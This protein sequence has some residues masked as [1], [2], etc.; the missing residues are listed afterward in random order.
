MASYKRSIFLINPKFQYRFS[1]FFVSFVLLATAI[2]P[3][4]IFDLFE[5]IIEMQ[6]EMAA[7]FQ[8]TRNS[9]LLVLGLVELTI[10]CFLF[11][12]SIFLSHKIAGP[13][14]KLT[15]HFEKI[16]EG[17]EIKPV[18][19]RDGD[20]FKEI[21][22]EVNLT[23]EYFANQRQEDF[24]YLDEVSAYIANLS[25]VVPEDKKPVL[26]EIQSNL[27]KIQSRNLENQL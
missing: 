19:F 5:K 14:Y 10:L 6:P 3:F 25:L 11:I 13:M 1:F 8:S 16:R 21:A 22:H 18:F 23:L 15:K 26:R 17:G 7:D 27:S 24:V 4:V 2:Y 20:Y 9:L 12:F